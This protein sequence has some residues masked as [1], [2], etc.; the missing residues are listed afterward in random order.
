MKRNIEVSFVLKVESICKKNGDFSLKDISFTL[1]PGYILGLIGCNGAGKTTTLKAIL[2]I[3][4]P[5]SG[6]AYLFEKD[7]LGGDASYK[8]EIG[9]VFGEFYYYG[10][11]RLRSITSVVKKFYDNW[12][13][14]TYRKYMD[15]F[16]LDEMKRVSELSTGMRIKYAITIAL[17]HNAKLFIFDEPTSGLDPVSRH[18]LLDIFGKIVADGKR[19][20]LFST[21]ITSDLDKCADYI[22]YIQNGR[23]IMNADRETVL[24]NFRLVSGARKQLTD[25][26]K[27][28]LIGYEINAFGF[29]GMMTAENASEY[30]DLQTARPDIESIMV[31]SE[32]NNKARRN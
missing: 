14:D 2:N 16:G 3:N 28:N 15:Y 17:S 21:H 4:K 20:I 23:V 8:Q 22:V 10:S 5:D 7:M 24:D 19:S 32:K 18:E 30:T 25:D 29:T 9:I 12:S 11:K 26:V 13:D 31:Y 27:E 1:E 6:R